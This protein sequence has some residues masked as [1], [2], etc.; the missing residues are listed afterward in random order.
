MHIS[1][2]LRYTIIKLVRFFYLVP[3]GYSNQVLEIF[4]TYFLSYLYLPDK[5][6]QPFAQPLSSLPERQWQPLSPFDATIAT[7][8]IFFHLRWPELTRSPAISTVLAGYISG[9][10]YY[11][12][13]F[14]RAHRRKY[15]NA[16]IVGRGH[17]DDGLQL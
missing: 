2:E 10:E 7:L 3:E 12:P 14:V 1:N 17:D 5:L 9:A 8:N 13:G 16:L 4:E 15:R 11:K 6:V